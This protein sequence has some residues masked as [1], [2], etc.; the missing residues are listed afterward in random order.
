M[1]TNYNKTHVSYD[2]VHNLIKS[3]AASVAN[4]FG[5]A[6]PIDYIIAISGGGLI[7]SR[8]LRTFIKVPI[9]VVGVC[10]YDE[11]GMQLQHVK[12]TQWLDNPQHIKNK[13]ILI[14]D[15]VDDTRKTLEFVVKEFH[16]LEPSNMGVMVLHNKDK[17]KAGA[18]DCNICKYFACSM[19]PDTHIVYPWDSQELLPIK[20]KLQYQRDKMLIINE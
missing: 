1:H 6:T 3:S 5:A 15:E 18:I 10:A 8:I 20:S 11:H 17:T 14:V 16:A 4:I 12:K 13:N 9:L 2:Q 19:V 7:P